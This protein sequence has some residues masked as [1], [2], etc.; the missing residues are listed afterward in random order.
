MIA[1]L[2]RAAVTTEKKLGRASLAMPQGDSVDTPLCI[3]FLVQGEPRVD[4][5]LNM[6]A[7]LTRYFDLSCKRPTGSS[8]F[9]GV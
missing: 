5:H 8:T 3:E 4:R 6:C 7:A 9:H 2:Q 1:Q